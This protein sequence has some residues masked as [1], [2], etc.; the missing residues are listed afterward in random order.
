MTPSAEEPPA[1]RFRNLSKRFRSQHVLR[2]VS[3][4]VRPG[5][6]F[7]LVGI[8][9]AGKTTCIKALLDFCSIDGGSV[10][11]FGVPRQATRSRERLAYLP[12]RFLPPY[13]LTGRSFLKFSARLYGAP[14]DGQTLAQVLKRLDFPHSAL[15]QP[16][17]EY[18][19]G[20]AQKLG[21]ASCFLSG[22]E[23]LVLDEPL[24][25]L[26]PKARILV[27]RYLQS[28]KQR[29]HSVFFS[30]HMLFDVQELCD[31]MGILHEGVLQFVGTPE[32]CRHRFGGSSLEEAYLACIGGDPEEYKGA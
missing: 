5:E 30:T 10:S 15:D 1:L 7:G 21:L 12:E 16:V 18:S 14:L 3:L 4:E 11:L 28:M 27:K 20:M 19:K 31:R 22:R 8:N 29:T 6:Y 32:E 17:R 25:G 9:G 26:D 13:F 23:L 2:D 24:S